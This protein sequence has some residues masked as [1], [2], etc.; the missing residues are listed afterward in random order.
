MQLTSPAFVSGGSIPPVYSCTGEET[1]P[2]LI[3]AGIPAETKSLALI[4]EDPDAPLEIWNHW[5][6]WNI[7]PTTDVVDSTAL[8]PGALQGTGSSGEQAYEGPCPPE[9]THRYV[10]TLYALDTVLNLPAGATK[11]ELLG[12]LRGHIITQT[13]LVGLYTRD[14]V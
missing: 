13:E 2:P 9:G 11:D 1:R 10:F 3:L 4:L 7:P 8:P 6:V 12:A 5:I 14:E